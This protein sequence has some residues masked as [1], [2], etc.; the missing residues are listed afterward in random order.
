[1]SDYNF[2]AGTKSKRNSALEK[3]TEEK[4]NQRKNTNMNYASAKVLILEMETESK[5]RKDIIKITP[6]GLVGSLRK[7]KSP[8]DNYA[9]FGYRDLGENVNK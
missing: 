8:D 4:I 9:Y 1:L 2:D 7:K 6:D 3:L 5:E